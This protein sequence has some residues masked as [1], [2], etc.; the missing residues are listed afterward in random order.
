MILLAIETTCDETGAAV[1]DG[2]DPMGSGVP[3]ILSSV[4]SSQI[5]LHEKYG[6]VVPEIAA[7]A[8]VRQLLPVVDEALKRAAVRLG[9][10]GAVAVATRPGL[11]GALI[12][13]LTAA[14]SL[15]LALDRPR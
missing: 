1:L 5:D 15:A 13:G 14:K 7:R 8:H 10:I 6:G 11:V 2:P 3:T 9:D 4:V 12:V